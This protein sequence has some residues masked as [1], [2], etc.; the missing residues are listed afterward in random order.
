[1]AISMGCPGSAGLEALLVRALERLEAVGH[2][3]EGRRGDPPA[4]AVVTSCA[5]TSAR[6]ARRAPPGYRPARPRELEVECWAESETTGRER[7]PFVPIGTSGGRSLPITTDDG[8]CL[9]MVLARF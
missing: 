2:H 8:R 3:P 4:H 5:A 6:G 1:Q 9:P 7:A